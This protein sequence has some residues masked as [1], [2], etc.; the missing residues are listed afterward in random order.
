M[1]I[2]GWVDTEF[3]SS[4]DLDGLRNV[5]VGQRIES[6]EVVDGEDIERMYRLIV[7]LEGGGKLEVEGQGPETS[8]TFVRV[9]PAQGGES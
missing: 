6:V 1:K 2:D 4:E 3:P 8:A 9:S 7:T 5:L